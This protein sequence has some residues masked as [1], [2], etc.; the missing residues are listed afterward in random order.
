MPNNKNTPAQKGERLQDAKN[1]QDL[2]I[3]FELACVRE[4]LKFEPQYGAE[5]MIRAKNQ[6]AMRSMLAVAPP[7]WRKEMA[8]YMRDTADLGFPETEA[9]DPFNG[10]VI[11]L[12]E[13]TAGATN[14][15]RSDVDIPGVVVR[16]R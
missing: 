5:N 7:E 4:K 8:L 11:E 16:H 2:L 3:R 9:V 13:I 14:K 6:Q 10:G 12:P 15:D 1:V